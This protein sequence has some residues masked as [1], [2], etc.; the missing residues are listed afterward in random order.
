VTER[1]TVREHLVGLLMERGLE[2]DQAETLIVNM[3]HQEGR[4]LRQHGL[5]KLDVSKEPHW[6]Y[7]DFNVLYRVAKKFS[8]VCSGLDGGKPY[9]PHKAL[10]AQLERLLPAFTDTEEIRAAMR[11]R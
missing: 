4:L 2:K 3:L 11:G 10:M 8:D 7:K 9:E 1:V 6:L 5:Q